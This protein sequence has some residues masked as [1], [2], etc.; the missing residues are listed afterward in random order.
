MWSLR[1]LVHGTTAVLS[2]H[3]HNLL[4]S[5]G[6]Q[7]NYGKAKF[8]SDLNCGQRLVSETGPWSSMI[9]RFCQWYKC[10]RITGVF[11]FVTVGVTGFKANFSCGAVDWR[12]FKRIYLHVPQ[13]QQVFWFTTI[14]ESNLYMTGYDMKSYGIMKLTA[15]IVIFRM[16]V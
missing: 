3:V 9:P 16:V 2:W 7:R 14:H 4:L 15:D 12:K 10:T 6:Q 5:D 13:S 11:Y 1:N 8:P